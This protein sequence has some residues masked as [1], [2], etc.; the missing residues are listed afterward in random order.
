MI[1]HVLANG[2]AGGTNLDPIYGKVMFWILAVLAV[3]ASVA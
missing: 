1:L 2:G 3:A